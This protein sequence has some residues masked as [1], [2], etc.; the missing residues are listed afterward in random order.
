MKYKIVIADV[1]G[2][3]IAPGASHLETASPRLI[4]TVEKTKK[5]GV[6]FSLATARSLDK[7]EGLIKSLK[8]NSL[9]ILNNGAS[10]YDCMVEKYIFNSFIPLK[11][12]EE[13]TELLK[14]YPY[15]FYIDGIGK[16]I[17][18]NPQ[19]GFPL[20]EIIKI[21]ILHIQ[22]FQA[23]QVFE[24][25]YKNN[26][27]RVTK[28][29]SGISP[30]KESI[31]ITNIDATKEKAAKRIADLSGVNMGQILTIGDSYNDFSLMS[32]SGFK[33][34]MGNAVPEIKAIADYIAPGYDEDGVAQTLE[35]FIL[36]NNE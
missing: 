23:Q 24:A 1:D 26:K 10:I 11:T 30:V 16:R 25:V 31:H 8:L 6:I 32:S 20:N 14:Q 15:T 36:K 29:I 7:I 28:S 2:T 12:V 22:P 19:K 35:E 27:V 33:V 21:V 17:E 4:E 34:A 9:I 5:L 3:M 13:I 18:Y